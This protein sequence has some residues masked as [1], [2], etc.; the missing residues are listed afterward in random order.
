MVWCHDFLWFSLGFPVVFLKFSYGILNVFLRF[1]LQLSYLFLPLF[2]WSTCNFPIVFLRFSCIF[3]FPK[4]PT[5]HPPN[6]FHRGGEGDNPPDPTTSTGGRGANPPLTTTSTGEGGS[7]GGE[8]G[9]PL[10]WDH[11]YD[12]EWGHLYGT[13]SFL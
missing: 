9:A 10:T 2:A 1:F 3:R 4:P 8:G 12:Y 6:H 7:W 13:F 11:L 5:N